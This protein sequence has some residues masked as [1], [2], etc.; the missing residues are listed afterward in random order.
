MEGLVLMLLGSSAAALPAT[1]AAPSQ[2]SPPAMPISY[3]YGGYPR[4]EAELQWGTKPQNQIK[5]V[6][7]TGSI[8][9]WTLGPN[10]TINDGSSARYVQGPCNKTVKNFYNWPASTT[11]SRLESVKGGIGYSYGGNGKL[12]S[13]NYHINDTIS[14]GNMKYPALANQQVSLAN[15]IQVAQL[16]DNCAIPESNFDHSILGL[17]PFGVGGSGIANIGPS[18]RKNLRDQGK[19]KSSS[20]SMWFDKPS[21][22][23]KNPHFGTALFGAVPDKSKYSGDLVRVKL[24]PPQEAYIGYY[25]S[26]PSMSAKQANHLSS[27]TSPIGISDK[28]VKQCLLDSGTGNDMLP[29]IGKD[30]FKASGLINYQSPE[31]TSIVAWN[32]TCDSIPVS[33]TLDYTF[34]GS[35]AGKS[36]TIKVPIRSYAGGQYDALADIPKNVCGL[37]VEFDEYGSCV[38]GAPFFTA[39]FAA[40]NDDKKQIALA[41]GGVSTGAAAGTP[42]L[43]SVSLIAPGQ[44]IPGSS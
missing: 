17:A 2:S 28:S 18:F 1:F 43:G 9:F 36:V 41:Q 39:V 30:V 38:F 25:V 22:D 5:T 3:S 24:N 21:A 42:G 44:D 12:V 32:G 23:V 27:K 20:F 29:F 11:H 13:G 15:Y 7:D 37:S 8:G 40:F 34:A 6:F 31:G 33:A 4:I 19:T 16:D 14:F 26:L 35:T 10:S